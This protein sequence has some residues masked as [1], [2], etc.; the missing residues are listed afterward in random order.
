MSTLN[1]SNLASVRREYPNWNTRARIRK[2]DEAGNRSR[3]SMP[4]AG[5]LFASALV[6][7]RTVPIFASAPNGLLSSSRRG[8]S[9]RV[10]SRRS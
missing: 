8:V 7:R 10:S 5:R 1:V 6:T 2:V 3:G 4:T 9:R